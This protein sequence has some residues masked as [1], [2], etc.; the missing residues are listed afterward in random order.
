MQQPLRDVSITTNGQLL[1]RKADLILD[2]GHQTLQRQPRYAESAARSRRSRAAATWRPCC[3]AS[4]DAARA[5][6]KLKINMVP[7]RHANLDQVLPLLEF[8]LER[9]I[10]LRYIELMNMGHLKHSHDYRARVRR[11]RRRLLQTIGER[12]EFARTDARVRLDVG[13]LRD[14]GRGR[15]RHH[16]ERVGAVLQRVHAVALVVERTSCTAA[17][18]TRIATTSAICSSGRT[19]SRWRSCRVC[20]FARSADKQQRLVSGRSHRDEVHRRLSRCA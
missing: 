7:M 3:A 18:R 5:G 11:A 10:E 4:S 12:Y 20:S 14:S 13:A 16:R 1:E 17:C 15:V 8:C 19:T 2:V 9:G 6:V